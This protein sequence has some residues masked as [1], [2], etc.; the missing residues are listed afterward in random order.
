MK[1]LKNN[2][3]DGF[4]CVNIIYAGLITDK[5]LITIDCMFGLSMMLWEWQKI[6]F[7]L[8]KKMKLN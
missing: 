4:N 5:I 1:K 2:K 7:F 6:C 8:K 3:I